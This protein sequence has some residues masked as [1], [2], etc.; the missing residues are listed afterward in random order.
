MS[1]T[2]DLDNLGFFNEKPKRT[3]NKKT[4]EEIMLSKA[5]LHFEKESQIKRLVYVL[6]RHFNINL[7]FD[8]DTLEKL[9][10]KT[11]NMIIKDLNGLVEDQI[12]AIRSYCK[13]QV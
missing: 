13:F 11:L 2:F 8:P 10:V 1:N 4:Q 6:S 3:Y 7:N 9:S 12:K 5:K